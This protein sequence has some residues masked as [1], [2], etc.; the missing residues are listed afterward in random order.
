MDMSTGTG[1]GVSDTRIVS[2]LKLSMTILRVEKGAADAD[3]D[4]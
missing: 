4:S 3:D 2:F 1:I